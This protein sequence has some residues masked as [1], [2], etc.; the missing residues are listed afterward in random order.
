MKICKVQRKS[1]D[2]SKIRNCGNFKNKRCH[3]IPKTRC[4]EAIL[5]N[6]CNTIPV[7]ECH[8]VPKQVC[9]HY[10]KICCKHKTGN[11]NNQFPLPKLNSAADVTGVDLDLGAYPTDECSDALVVVHVTSPLEGPPFHRRACDGPAQAHDGLCT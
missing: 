2:V 9:F 1:Y 5:R 11:V 6:K 7:K 4:K 8:Q 3:Q 10:K